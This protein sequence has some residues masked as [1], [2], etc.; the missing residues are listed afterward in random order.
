[1]TMSESLW[2]QPGAFCTCGTFFVDFEKAPAS[3]GG[4]MVVH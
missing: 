1:M 3:D 2:Q 4:R